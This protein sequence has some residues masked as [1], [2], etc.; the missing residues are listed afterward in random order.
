LAALPDLPG[1]QAA[2]GRVKF[3]QQRYADA[4]DLMRR[5]KSASGQPPALYDL[6]KATHEVT[7]DFVTYR[8]QK[9]IVRVAPGP[10]EVLMPYL[11]EAL[12]Q[13]IERLG[14]RFGVVIERPLVVEVY[15]S[16]KTF[17]RV[18]T[19][20]LK[21][22]ETSGT[23][24]LCKFDRLMLIT[25]RVTM[26][27]YD[28]LDTV[29]H[30]LIHLLISR[31][32]HDTV[33]VWLHEGLAKYHESGWRKAFGEPLSPYSAS[34]L[35]KAVNRG[36]LITFA[37]MSPSMAYLPSQEATATAFAEVHT[38]MEY[39]IETYGAGSILKLLDGLRTS[40]GNVD[41]AFQAVTG[42]SLAVF[43]K[44]WS[45]WLK[46]R[47]FE[48]RDGAR[49]PALHFGVNRAA[50]DDDDPERPDGEA[51]RYA[52]LGDLLY[53]RGHKQAAAVEYRRSIKRAG[54]GY[55]GL[56]HRLASSLIAGSQLSEA[57]DVLK[58]SSARSPDD[59]RTHVLLGR[60]ALKG[61]RYQAA[62]DAYS[63]VNG[64]N[65]FDPECHEGMRSAAKALKKDELVA[66]ETEALKHLRPADEEA[67]PKK[68]AGQVGYVHLTT[69]PW[70]EV[71]IDDQAIERATPLMDYPL[72]VGRHRITLRNTALSLERTLD[73]VIV[74]GQTTTLDVDLRT[75]P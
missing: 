44:R 30:E 57:Q 53:R 48:T 11:A 36:E 49:A 10:D 20:S 70:A 61:K 1:I 14:P 35:A 60:L 67:P 43:E 2:A 42:G 19:L 69:Q 73:V 71:I 56:V 38:A 22:I 25:P 72:A 16:V 29:S 17:S 52:R 68:P 33:P 55:A 62:L 37:Q 45:L 47:P 26:R 46:K 21:A 8:A 13:A 5:A 9:V 41:A 27:G 7:A 40:G 66:R 4:L 31:R 39:L 32:S 63:R 64:I 24:A 15:P 54:Y 23:I 51:G 12:N 18:S 28:W 58:R 65:P 75:K 3:H 59:P 50:A 74:L 34:L 6:I